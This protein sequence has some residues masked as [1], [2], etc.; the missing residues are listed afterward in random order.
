MTGIILAAVGSLFAEI[1]LSIGKVKAQLKQESIYSMGFLSLFWG[2]LFFLALALFVPSSFVFS[3]QSLPT[4]IPRVFLEIAQAHVTMLAITRSPRSSFG[5]IRTGTIPLLLLVDVV[6]GYT[7][8]TTHI[9]GMGVIMLTLAL[10]FMNHGIEKKGSG[11]VLFTTVNAVATISLYKYNISHF[12][13]VVGEQL[14]V[15]L[16]LFAYFLAISWLVTKERP[17][18]MLA[19]PIFFAQSASEGLASIIM[20]FAY[21]FA[22]ASVITAAKRAFE[23]LWSI[24]S[25]NR[26]FH[27]KRALFKL[28]AFA[29]LAIGIALLI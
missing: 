22:P 18:R 3:L 20:S 28:V 25:G 13:S 9:I 4:F 19:K 26:V 8:G 10:L 24:V 7:I 5:F 2:S 23:I 16:A 17:F 1:S 15:Y 12:N 11:L 29:L 27:E 21:G 6:L 14:F